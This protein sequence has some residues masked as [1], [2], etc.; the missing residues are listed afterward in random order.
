VDDQ[1]R[2]GM[3]KDYAIGRAWDSPEAVTP[4]T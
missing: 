3:E 4:E 1:V 2:A